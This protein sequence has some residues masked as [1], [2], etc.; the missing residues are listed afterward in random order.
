MK[1]F[2]IELITELKWLLNYSVV[3][4]WGYDNFLSFRYKGR[5][6]RI[7]LC[8]AGPYWVCTLIEFEKIDFRIVKESNEITNFS[9]IN[10]PLHKAR[11]FAFEACK[12]F[13]Q[14]PK[15]ELTADEYF[16]LTD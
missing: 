9:Q 5:F 3:E 16:N 12:E 4:W 13:L 8:E 2:I 6:F 11:E 15:I 14:F 10:N 1:K 7:D